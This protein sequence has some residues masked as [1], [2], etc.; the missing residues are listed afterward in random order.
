[1]YQHYQAMVRS[2]NLELFTAKHWLMDAEIAY[3][4]LSKEVD[5]IF[6]VGFSMGGI[7]AMYLALRYKVKALVLLSPAARY[8]R[9]KQFVID[10]NGLFLEPGM[11]IIQEMSFLNVYERKII[12]VP[13]IISG[14]IYDD[15]YIKYL[16]IMKKLQFQ[17]V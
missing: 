8:I 14:G 13:F 3:K 16:L 6:I 11:V 15:W 4:R 2:L 12:D 7:I 1:M 10:L 9:T 17:Y 5:E